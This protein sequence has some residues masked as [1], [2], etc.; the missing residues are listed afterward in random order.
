MD[1]YKSI[2]MN[3]SLWKFS[4]VFL[5]MVPNGTFLGFI[6][7]ELYFIKVFLNDE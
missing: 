4:T 3:K 1:A 6:L 7:Q 2:N 5:T